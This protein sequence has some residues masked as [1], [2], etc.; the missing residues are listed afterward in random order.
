MTFSIYN[1]DFCVCVDVYSEMCICTA[2]DPFHCQAYKAVPAAQLNK[3]VHVFHTAKHIAL[4]LE[5]LQK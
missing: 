1:V 3:L 5:A 2:R 4:T